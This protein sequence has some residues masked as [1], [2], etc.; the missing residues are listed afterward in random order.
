MPRANGISAGAERALLRPDAAPVLVAA[1]GMGFASAAY[2]T[3]A[4]EVVV[5]VG[6]LPRSMS[7]LAWVVIGIAGLLGGAAGDLIRR[8]EINAVHR[9]SLLALATAGLVLVLS[10]SE[11]TAVLTSAALFGAAYIMLTGVYLVWGIR[12]Y[13]D[14]PAV[15]LALPFLM[16][17]LGQVAGAPVA[18][19][20]IGISGHAATFA[21]FAAI[22]TS[23]T[24]TAYRP[25][26][27]HG[28]T[29]ARQGLPDPC[30][31]CAE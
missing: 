8:F 26:A 9:G 14:R 25:A 27:L 30:C 19:V 6:R 11:P 16:I 22:A 2:W 17:A 7:S 13:D 18:G 10:P 20:L 4:G 12:V 21:V 28:P 15:G 3:F 31:A 1:T 5:D 29:L 24:L 23:A